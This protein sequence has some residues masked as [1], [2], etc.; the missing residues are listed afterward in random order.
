MFDLGRRT[1][2]QNYSFEYNKHVR[3]AKCELCPGLQSLLSAVS[4]F[5]A[6]LLGL[7]AAL[8]RSQNFALIYDMHV[9]LKVDV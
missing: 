8:T 2:I 1:R 6:E 7:L 4:S 5:C 9:V 3:N